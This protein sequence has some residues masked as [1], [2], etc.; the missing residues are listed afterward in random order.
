[1]FVFPSKYSQESHLI[2]AFEGAA[3]LPSSGF[4]RACDTAKGIIGGTDIPANW[5]SG[6]LDLYENIQEH[7]KELEA[8]LNFASIANDVK[9]L[10]EFCRRLEKQAPIIVPIESLAPEPYELIKPI[11]IVV[12]KVDDQYQATFFDALIA[13]SG[14]TPEEAVFNFKDILIS[15]YDTLSTISENKL[16]TTPSKQLKVLKEFIKPKT[17]VGRN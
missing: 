16:G 10:K 3:F 12:K 11:H 14:D 2:T 15:I 7:F 9:L 17:D 4:N 6:L 5:E 1:M 8:S 13:T